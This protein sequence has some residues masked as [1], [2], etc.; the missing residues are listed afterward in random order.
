MIV[1]IAR[2]P[3]LG[4]ALALA[5]VALGGVTGSGACAQTAV[6]V[7]SPFELAFWQSVAS[8][9]DPALFQAYLRQ[10]PE[11][12]FAAI[13][14]VKLGA[15]ASSAPVPPTG[16]SPAGAGSTAAPATP[17]GADLVTAPAAA[18]APAPGPL[19]AVAVPADDGVTRQSAASM[20]SPAATPGEAAPGNVALARLASAQMTPSAQTAP[21][22]A[23]APH[24]LPAR[25]E[26]AAVPLVTLPA[27]FC[28]VSDRNR[29]HAAVYAPAMAMAARNNDAAVAYM[30]QLQSLYDSNQLGDE[31]LRVA[32]VTEAG[33]FRQQASLTYAIQDR[34]VRQFDQLMA[35]P[36]QPC[37]TL[38]ASATA[39]VAQ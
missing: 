39:P 31:R 30:H 34:M 35:V 27:S 28:S 14:R 8:G 19:V 11:G 36:V 7:G 29:F 23:A 4:S 37:G 20:A 16:A 18:A 17:A 32:I 10:F 1:D 6:G 3:A 5:L 21:V 33:A 13:A 12:T 2:R 25:P 15:S 38:L 24:A 9:N 26:F 22:V